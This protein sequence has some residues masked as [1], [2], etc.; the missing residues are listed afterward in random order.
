MVASEIGRSGFSGGFDND[1]QASPILWG[2]PQNSH[3]LALLRASHQNQN[4]NPNPNP[5]CNSVNVKEEGAMNMIGSHMMTTEPAMSTARTLGLDPVCQAPSLELF[6]RLRSS[7]SSSGGY[8]S[9]HLNNV[10]MSSS[11]STSSILDSTP[12][13]GGGEM[14][15]WNPAFTAWSSDLPTTNGAYH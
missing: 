15:Y 7:S 11:S 8:Y 5:I 3:L 2:S 14:G 4:P 13:V 6:Q 1:V 10:V 9:D 12:A